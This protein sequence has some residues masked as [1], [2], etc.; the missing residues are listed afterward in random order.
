MKP[1]LKYALPMTA[2]IVV[3]SGCASRR[4]TPAEEATPEP[5]L[6]VDV[7]NLRPSLP[8]GAVGIMPKAVLY[9]TAGDFRDNV[10]VQV[11]PDGALISFPAPTDIPANPA[12]VEFAGGWLLSPVGVSNQT[13]FTTYTYDEYRNLKKAPAPEE[14][15]KAVIPGS[16]VTATTQV[17][18]TVSEALAD[19]EA[20]NGHLSPSV[21]L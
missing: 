16:R 14:L 18:M 6:K 11:G 20:V 17:P 7:S 1:L 19:P 5:Q 15:L 13:M 21:K 3:T 9:K 2:A 12:P 8:Q 10:P 4:T